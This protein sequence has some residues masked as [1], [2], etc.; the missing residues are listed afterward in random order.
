MMLA[1]MLLGQELLIF[2]SLVGMAF[3]AVICQY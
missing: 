1:H 2:I 3:I